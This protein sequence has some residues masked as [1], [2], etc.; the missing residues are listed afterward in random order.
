MVLG[1]EV[2]DGGAVFDGGELRIEEDIFRRHGEV[3]SICGQSG[4]VWL[5][6]C[7]VR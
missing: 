6:G 4:F 7:E 5:M 1:A 3:N 2:V